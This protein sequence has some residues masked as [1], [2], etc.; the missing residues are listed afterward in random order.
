LLPLLKF[1]TS[2][3]TKKELFD[4]FLFLLQQENINRE[5]LNSKLFNGEANGKRRKRKRKNQRA[6]SGEA[7]VLSNANIKARS[8]MNL[9]NNEAGRRVRMLNRV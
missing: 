9:H 2:S 7:P 8:L 5:I 3:F 1:Q 6:V 4:L